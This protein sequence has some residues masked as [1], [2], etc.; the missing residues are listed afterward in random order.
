MINIIVNVPTDF[1]FVEDLDVIINI[2][3]YVEGGDHF[4][5]TQSICSKQC[6]GNC[7]GKNNK[8]KET[9]EE[10]EILIEDAT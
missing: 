5:S 8:E 9:E 6:K 2:G 7:C 1:P 4:C 10:K 3:E